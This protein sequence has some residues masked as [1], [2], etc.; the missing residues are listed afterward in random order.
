MSDFTKLLHGIERAV[1]P[2]KELRDVLQFI[3]PW[4]IVELDLAAE[5]VRQ[6][7]TKEEAEA[8]AKEIT[9]WFQERLV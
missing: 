3:V 5:L 2:P 9:G 8:A 1:T 6:G 7:A 4:N